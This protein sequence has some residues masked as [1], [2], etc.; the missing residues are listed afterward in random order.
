LLAVETV[1]RDMDEEE[2]NYRNTLLVLCCQYLFEQDARMFNAVSNSTGQMSLLSHIA[3]SFAFKF[4][5]LLTM[6][7]QQTISPIIW[8]NLQR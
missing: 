3:K 2:K 1:I 7:L 5:I 8:E 4:L 6:E